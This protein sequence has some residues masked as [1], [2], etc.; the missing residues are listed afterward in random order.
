MQDRAAGEAF[1]IARA[2]FSE[3]EQCRFSSNER[4]AEAPVQRAV[5]SPCAHHRACPQI[6]I[7]ALD[8]KS[9]LKIPFEGED[10]GAE[11]HPGSRALGGFC[12]ERIQTAP[13]N[14]HRGLRKEG[15]DGD[16][17]A[18]DEPEA[19][20][21]FRLVPSKLFSQSH[22][23]QNRERFVRKKAPADLVAREAR[24]LEDDYARP[25]A[26]QGAR[27]GG[28][29][30][31]AADHRDVAIVLQG[32]FQTSSQTKREA[33]VTR[34]PG[35]TGAA[36]VAISSALEACLPGSLPYPPARDP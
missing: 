35:R 12:G 29:R 8:A 15:L 22:S 17:V 6:P 2:Y 18:P 24:F 10:G 20:D 1:A 34:A 27:R 19:R 3:S 33:I 4:A 36:I 31:A 5:A 28:A 11:A 26:C 9:F 14:R 25:G 13:R 32:R 7:E 30:E 16:A 21:R 23:A